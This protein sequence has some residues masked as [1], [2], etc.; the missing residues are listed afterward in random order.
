VS[1]ARHRVLFVDDDP[2]VLGGLRA[3]LRRHRDR[4]DMVFEESPVH[5]AERLAAEPFD[6]LVTDMRMPQ[7]DGAELLGVAVD[8]APETARVVLSGHADT[9]RAL[10]AMHLS[11]QYL[12]KPCDAQLLRSV[13]TRSVEVHGLLQS[14]ALRRL[15]AGVT[16]LPAVPRT[17]QR[18]CGVLTDP[19]AEAADVAAV[20]SADAGLTTQLLRLVNSPYFRRGEP[21]SE[22]S[23]AVA[24]MGTTRIRDL[25]LS[26][27]VFGMVDERAVDRR[28]ALDERASRATARA[29]LAR[30]I[31]AEEERDHAY[32]AGL[33]CDAGL[34]A[35]TVLPDAPLGPTLDRVDAGEP[36]SCAERE[37]L[38]AT[39]GAIGAYL[40]SLWGLPYAVVHAVGHHQE[41]SGADPAL[42]A[43][44]AVR[45]ATL[46]LP[47]PAERLDADAVGRELEA[48]A[49]ARGTS[50]ARWIDLA[51]SLEAAR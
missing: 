7:M 8:V 6:V 35:L 28:L 32:L 36:L 39:H 10:M 14:A 23:R 9:E 21:A 19:R 31:A 1:E 38:G 48:M 43:S 46:L 47:D 25:T 27:E 16:E 3:V 33:L 40:L 24:L 22:V 37:T 42:D 4:L 11:H 45:V 30:S 5:A 17:Y 12:A 18:L 51:L 2:R 34:L 26:A 13:L 49:A 29:R 44:A 50:A 20:I 41:P 15:L